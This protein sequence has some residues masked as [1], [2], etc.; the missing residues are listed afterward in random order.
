MRVMTKHGQSGLMRSHACDP[1]P[2]RRANNIDQALNVA[3]YTVQ[4]LANNPW[5][6]SSYQAQ[7]SIIYSIII[8][9]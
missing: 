2:G 9:V 4:T 7:T 8:T 1:A 3:T 6:R 5:D